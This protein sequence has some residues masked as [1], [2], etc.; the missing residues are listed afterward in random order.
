MRTPYVND[1]PTSSD[2]RGC[3]KQYLE[4]LSPGQTRIYCKVIPD[5]F[6]TVNSGWFW[7]LFYSIVL[8]GKNMIVALFEEGAAILGLPNHK[9]FSAHSLCAMFVTKLANGKGVSDQERMASSRHNSVAS[10][11]Y[12]ERNNESESN[13]FA[14]LGIMPLQKKKW[15]FFVCI[16]CCIIYSLLLT[17]IFF[18]IICS[19]HRL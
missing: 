18:Q 16:F 12:Q 17:Y 1:D 15:E 19:N 5:E 3:V 4:K 6:R 13:R 9:Y 14:A 2:F 8:L 11:I 10:V 7:P